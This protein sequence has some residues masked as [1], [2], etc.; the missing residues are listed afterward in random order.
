M[1][2]SAIAKPTLSVDHLMDAPLPQLIA[3]LHVELTEAG[4]TDAGFTGYAYVSRDEVVVALPPN[5]SEFEH[6]CIAR[7]LIGSVFHVDGMPPL[8]EAFQITD[9][10]ADVNRA[11]RDQA[12][13]VV[14]QSREGG[15]V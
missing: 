14:R 15:A 13:E 5:R 3:E 12:A 1:A 4:I 10:T 6:D 8:P 7:Y 11:H 2:Q 9:M